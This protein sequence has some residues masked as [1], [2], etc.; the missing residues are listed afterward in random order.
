[1]NIEKPQTLVYLFPSQNPFKRQYNV[2]DRP[3]ISNWCTTTEKCSEFLDY[4]LK[5]LMQRGF[6]VH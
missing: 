6:V 4:H 5:P 1:M 2:P 3:V